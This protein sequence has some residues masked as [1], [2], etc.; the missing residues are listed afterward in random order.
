MALWLALACHAG[1]AGIR[2]HHHEAPIPQW[3]D[4]SHSPTAG[5]SRVAFGS[6]VYHPQLPI[7]TQDCPDR[8]PLDTLAVTVA[9]QHCLNALRQAG[10][11]QSSADTVHMLSD[12]LLPRVEVTLHIGPSYVLQAPDTL[13]GT[14]FTPSSP[15]ALAKDFALRTSPPLPEAGWVG[16]LTTLDAAGSA[17]VVV[18]HDSLSQ[19]PLLGVQQMGT[20]RIAPKVLMRLLGLR[21]GQAFHPRMTKEL[22]ALIHAVPFA[23]L[24][25]DM[26]P[27]VLSHGVRL[28]AEID[29][30][31]AN[32]LSGNL[33]LTPSTR[34]R[35]YDWSGYVRGELHNLFAQA[36]QIA[37]SWTGNAQRLH[38]LNA[39]TDW[40]YLFGSSWGTDVTLALRRHDTISGYFRGT[41]ALTY[42]L[43]PRQRVYLG[44]L[45]QNA[46][47]AAT[48]TQA[49]GHQAQ[50]QLVTLGYAYTAANYSGG[51][52]DGLRL[53]LESSLGTRSV[54]ERARGS[55]Y[56]FA[57][58]LSVSQ[59]V[60]RYGFVARAHLR[61]EGYIP[62]FRG[63]PLTEGELLRYG[64][65]ATMRG[66]YEA[67][68]ASTAYVTAGVEPTWR[69]G[70][71]VSLA[72][73]VDASRAWQTHSRPYLLGYG[74]ASTV[75]VGAGEFRLGI[76]R[77]HSWPAGT[78]P[79]QWLLHLELQLT[80]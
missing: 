64:G 12:T 2:E 46:N 14:T 51:W 25:G 40:P 63:E 26:A 71:W 55:L 38:T 45:Y 27:E 34:G 41:F 1:Y 16:T 23:T 66:F 47:S 10:Y 22:P 56:R 4:S 7:A 36:E 33:A 42:A 30:H 53:T 79:G 29:R 70:R 43:T 24:R 13:R 19:L 18:Y 62:L 61:A 32:T 31:H 69:I 58:R 76:A 54:D 5:S 77:G 48:S 8:L 72:L 44:F 49:E 52:Q 60:G 35:G 57:S 9:L 37:F 67:Q 50:S 28:H 6:V 68:I 59:P 65:S 73:L 75:R 20:L 11:L 21:P 3:R 78:A 17:S 39:H 74:A 80:F 15:R